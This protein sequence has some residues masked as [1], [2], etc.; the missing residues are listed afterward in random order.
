[1]K[2][3]QKYARRH[4][5]KLNTTLCNPHTAFSNR[6][7]STMTPFDFRLTF[8]DFVLAFGVVFTYS[9]ESSRCH[10]CADV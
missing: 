1:M 4:A 3:A 7:P 2:V 5:T 9:V 8:I 6:L 10:F